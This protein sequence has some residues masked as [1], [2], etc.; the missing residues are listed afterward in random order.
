MIWKKLN[1]PGVPLYINRYGQIR[2]KFRT[3]SG[4]VER[5]QI[6]PQVKVG[7][8][9]WGFTRR[10]KGKQ[11]NYLTH[12][13]LAKAF[14]KNPK[15]LPRVKFKNG[16]KDHVFLSNLEWDTSTGRRAGT[17]LK[18]N[19]ALHIKVRYKKGIPACQLAKHY[20]VTVSHIHMILRGERW[21]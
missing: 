2:E 20:K 8:G 7:N 21:A 10:V 17:R 16:N 15:R 14:L 12:I 13:L 9:Y 11:K 3:R 4:Q 6:L 19:D 18:A 1:V 5:N